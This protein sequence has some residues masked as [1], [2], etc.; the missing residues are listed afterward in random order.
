MW[1]SLSCDSVSDKAILLSYYI[2]IRFFSSWM[3]NLLPTL[4]RNNY[5]MN[6]AEILHK[7]LAA[8]IS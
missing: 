4:S 1:A 8:T 3:Y 6:Q 2:K 5:G 7:L